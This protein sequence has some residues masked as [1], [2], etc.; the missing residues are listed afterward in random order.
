MSP[1]GGK[2]YSPLLESEW[3]CSSQV[4]H[5]S[6]LP[7]RKNLVSAARNVGSCCLVLSAP[8]ACTSALTPRP[9]P[10]GAAPPMTQQDWDPSLGHFCPTWA[11]FS[12]QSLLQSLRLVGP[13]LSS[14]HCHL[15]FFLPLLAPALSFTGVRATLL[16]PI[17]LP[18]PAASQA[19]PPVN[20]L[21]SQL[22]VGLCF[23]GTCQTPPTACCLITNGMWRKCHCMTPGTG[24]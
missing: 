15:R 6:D 1:F 14:L 3:A 10:S 2:A 5:F 13:P 19:S 18:L 12:G 20:L 9:C 24:A 17:L 23:P 7:S 11:A 22:C 8:A 16:L 21:Y 4:V